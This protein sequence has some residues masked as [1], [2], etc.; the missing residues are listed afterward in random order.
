MLSPSIYTHPLSKTS[1]QQ[2]VWF[3]IINSIL[4]QQGIASV[5]VLPEHILQ[6]M[7]DSLLL[8][9]C[10]QINKEFHIFFSSHVLTESWG[11]WNKSSLSGL[12]SPLLSYHLWPAFLPDQLFFTIYAESLSAV[13]HYFLSPNVIIIYSVMCTTIQLFHLSKFQI[14][15]G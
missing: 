10:C 7:S 14:K 9:F 13:F 8:F 15:S 3:I 1:T 2:T 12:S 5:L 4:S 11:I 6:G